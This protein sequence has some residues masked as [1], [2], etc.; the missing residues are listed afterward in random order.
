M[1]DD[2]YAAKAE[3]TSVKQGPLGQL[4]DQQDRTA[5]LL[6][7]LADKLKPVMVPVPVDPKDRQDN[8]FHVETALYKQREVNE[9]IGFLIDSVSL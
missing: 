7:V 3:L 8:G 9:A 2:V 6:G 5:E 4:L 1:T